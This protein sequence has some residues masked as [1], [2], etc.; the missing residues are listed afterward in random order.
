MSE[1]WEKEMKEFRMRI[2][3][4]KELREDLDWIG[5]LMQLAYEELGDKIAWEALE[6]PYFKPRYNTTARVAK[7]KLTKRIHEMENNLKL[8]IPKEVK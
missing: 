1:D 4:L 5:S 2:E 8:L 3:N 6:P 7:S